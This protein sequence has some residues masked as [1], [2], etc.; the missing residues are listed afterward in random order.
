M[1]ALRAACDLLLRCTGCRVCRPCA[2]MMVC[3]LPDDRV[4]AVC[5]R[6]FGARAAWARGARWVWSVR[7]RRRALLAVPSRSAASAVKSPMGRTRARRASTRSTCPRV[8]H[9][10]TESRPTSSSR[11]AARLTAA[12]RRRVTART[13]TAARDSARAR[14]VEPPTMPRERSGFSPGRVFRGG[15]DPEPVR[16][17]CDAS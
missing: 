8:A 12:R 5:G 7:R 2:L 6:L 14:A 16:V 9:V 3:H 4:R 1:G 15:C 17:P 10:I 13:V 11:E